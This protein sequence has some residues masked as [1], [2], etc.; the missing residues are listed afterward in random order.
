MAF[1]SREYEWGD[2]SLTV[3]GR[4]VTGIRGV[5]Y[6]E[7]IEREAIYGK[8]RY[9]HSIQSGNVSIDGEVTLLQ[10][11]VEALAREGRGSIL[12]LAVDIV[13]SYGNP[14]NGDAIQV[15]RIEGARF[16]EDTREMKNG[17]KFMEVKIPFIAL[18][19]R[20]GI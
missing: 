9:P 11:E 8:G 10:S 13:V 7:K 19:V 6:K 15:D 3:G 20:K 2:I 18:N 1:D 5:S 14:G 16:L 4:D 17:D 12:S